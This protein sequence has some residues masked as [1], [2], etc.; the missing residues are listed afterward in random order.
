M[1]KGTKL[2][3]R[4]VIDIATAE[5]LGY[6]SDLEIDEVSGCVTAIIVRKSAG[7]WGNFFGFGEVNIPWHCVVAM[8][9]EFV[10]VKTF[11]FTEKCLKN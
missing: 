9:N 6:V 5:G 2:R 10:L 11:D 7:L 1:F 8:G 3:K 4:I